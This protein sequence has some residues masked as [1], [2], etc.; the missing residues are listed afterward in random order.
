[1]WFTCKVR[2]I[3]STYSGYYPQA[4]GIADIVPDTGSVDSY[5]IC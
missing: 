2:F 4:C 3:K 5:S 1:M